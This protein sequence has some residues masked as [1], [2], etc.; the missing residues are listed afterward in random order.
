MPSAPILTRTL[1][2]EAL[3]DGT[4]HQLDWNLVTTSLGQM[5]EP[6]SLVRQAPVQNEDFLDSGY[7]GMRKLQSDVMYTQIGFAGSQWPHYRAN[8][9][10]VD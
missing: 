5:V 1:L 6:R 8:D 4:I 7:S 10:G 2:W 9:P 3:S